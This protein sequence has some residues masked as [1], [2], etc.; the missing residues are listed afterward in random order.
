MAQFITR[1]ELHD[2]ATGEQYQTLH[3]AMQKEGFSRIITTNNGQ[4]YNLP[5]AE[6]NR[7]DNVPVENILQ[8]AERA[9]K[10]VGKRYSIITS[11]IVRASI[12]G[13]HLVKK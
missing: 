3:D 10:T 6:Y 5:T 11:E 13:L 1:V 7:Y 12:I 4:K 2:Y 8:S 9:A